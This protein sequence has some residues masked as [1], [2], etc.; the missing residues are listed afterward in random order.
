MP[1]LKID[2]VTQRFGGV[3]AVSD[4]KDILKIGKKNKAENEGPGEDE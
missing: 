1:L 2:H 3:I 4:V